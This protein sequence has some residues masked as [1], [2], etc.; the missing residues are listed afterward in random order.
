MIKLLRHNTAVTETLE[1]FPSVNGA[2][3]PIPPLAMPY[4]VCG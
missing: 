3:A 2:H 1:N 4:K